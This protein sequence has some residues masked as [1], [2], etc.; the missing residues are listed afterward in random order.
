MQSDTYQ[1]DYGAIVLDS[2]ARQTL[3]YNSSVTRNT[4]VFNDALLT[5]S[6]GAAFVNKRPAFI[7]HQRH[8]LG[9]VSKG[10]AHLHVKMLDL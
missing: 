9:V 5:I 2:L 6:Y 10:L 4:H 1:T 8:L 7:L 3:D